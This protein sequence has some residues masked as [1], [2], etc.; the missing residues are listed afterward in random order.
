[1]KGLTDR[2]GEQSVMTLQYRKIKTDSSGFAK[3][4]NINKI[5]MD[6]KLVG[7]INFYTAKFG[8]DAVI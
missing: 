8:N 2:G 6:A 4:L 5:E 7:N 1:M 3:L